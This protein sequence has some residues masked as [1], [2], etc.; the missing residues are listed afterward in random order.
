MSLVHK[1]ATNLSFVKIKRSLKNNLTEL[2]F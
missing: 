2:F 1:H